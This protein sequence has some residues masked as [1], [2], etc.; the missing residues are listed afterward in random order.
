MLKNNVEA[1]KMQDEVNQESIDRAKRDMA[2]E[3]A[4]VRVSF[5]MHDLSK[6]AKD[7]ASAAVFMTLLLNIL[8]WGCALV[9]KTQP[10]VDIIGQR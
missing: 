6:R 7:L 2:L 3:A 4:I 10:L 1:E 5:E 9:I 8:V